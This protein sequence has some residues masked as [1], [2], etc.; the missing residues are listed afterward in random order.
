MSQPLAEPL[1]FVTFGAA[2]K[3]LRKRARLTQDELGRAVGYGREQIARLENG[4]R[5]PDLTVLAALFVPA[6]ELQREPL[7]VTRLLEL[8]AAARQEQEPAGDTV[9]ITVTHATQRRVEV[10]QTILEPAF[11]AALSAGTVHRPPAPLFPLIG[12]QSAVAQACTLLRGD[13]RLLTLVGPPGVGKTRLA[14]EIGRQLAADFAHG[15]GWVPLA[16]VQND[17]DLAAA[18]TTALAIHPGPTQNPDE[19]VRAYLGS[20]ALLLILDN[21]EHL[22]AAAPQVSTWL[23]LA[24]QLKVLSTS[25]TALDLYG[26]YELAV[27]PLALPT[28]AHLPPLEELAQVS[29]VQLFAERARAVDL[30]F[31]LN[32]ENALAVAGLCVALD[33]LPLAI[34]LAA[35]RSRTL[36]PQELLQQIVAA[37]QHH[38]PAGALLAQS[39]RGV[40]ERH[41][42]LHEAIDWSY[43][44]LAPADQAVLARLGVFVG[45]CTA[46]AAAA[47]C[48]ATAAN[49]QAL[50]QASL[51]QTEP[52]VADETG[53]TIRL[54]LLETLRAYA[55]EQLV[56]QETLRTLQTLHADYFAA[57]AQ[58]IFAGL[59]GEE[60]A[61]WMQRALRDHDNLRAAL[62]F[63]LH[64]GRGEN[65][66]AIAGGLWWFWNR[67]GLLREGSAWLEASLNCPP[68][69]DPPGDRY[70]QHRSRALNGAGSLATELGEF[71]NALRYHQEGLALRRA[72]G[73]HAGAADVLHNLALTARC[74][75][76]FAQALQWFEES[77]DEMVQLGH[78][79]ESDVMACANIGITH[80]E[81]GNLALALPWLETALVSAQSQSDGWRTA[82]VAANLASLLLAQGELARAEQ[83]AQESVQ[84]FERLGDQFFLAEALLVLA[85]VMV[86]RGDLRQAHELCRTTLEIH[87]A[88][89]D[90]HGIAN[91]LQVQ[92]WLALEGGD[93]TDQTDQPDPAERR[94]LACRL[95]EQ[96]RT[97]R[98]S[99]P[100]A[101]A[102]YEQ[103]EYERLR[104][105][106]NA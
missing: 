19:A 97:L 74:Q 10:S 95:F 8:A 91:V 26:E 30:E 9:R 21:F 18:V 105:A 54:G 83:L 15:A 22:L 1:P 100:R 41:R 68:Q 17:G 43:R 4:S 31:R 35:A 99:V 28:L 51:L 75:G 44:L 3:F 87:R 16:P 29:A 49:V 79:P 58:E 89:D 32:A 46:A 7:L 60:Q 53:S 12:R 11:P 67:Q 94:D 88:I 14:L 61:L 106:L 57:Y 93:R 5:L 20:H 63:A 98:A 33:G 102:P 96:A 39:T 64:E 13:A 73:D 47:I 36:A 86:R 65:A 6:L 70:R 78:A 52:G 69:E 76:D 37:R 92:A 90:R 82:Y 24:P 27:A 23:Q 50:V 85:K 56:A 38:R 101:P 2:L 84:D 48:G 40:D 81:M 104:T 72:L 103:A 66:V 34:E 25:R 71:A 42:A 80:F 45:G 55:V 62:R 59:L 77:L